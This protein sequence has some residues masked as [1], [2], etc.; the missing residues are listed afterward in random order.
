MP[1]TPTGAQQYAHDSA[2]PVIPQ[3]TPRAPH[4]PPLQKPRPAPPGYDYEH[5]SRLAGPLTQPPA[6]S[7][8]T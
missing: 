7:T 5:Y 4:S 2:V 3:R 6:G 8:Y 1:P